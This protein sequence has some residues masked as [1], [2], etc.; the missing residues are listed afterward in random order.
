MPGRYKFEA[1][2]KKETQKRQN[3]RKKKFYF[4]KNVLKHPA[5]LCFGFLSLARKRNVFIPNR[6]TKRINVCAQFFIH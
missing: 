6:F 2:K 3:I 4:A 1:I 5:V